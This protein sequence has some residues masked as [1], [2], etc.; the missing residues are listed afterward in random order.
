TRSRRGRRSS[1][2]LITTATPPTRSGLG[3]IQP[4]RVRSGSFPPM[5]KAYTQLAQV[6]RETGL[7]RRTPWFYTAVMTAITLGFGGAITGFILL[8]DSW[9]QL[10]I[11]GG[12]GL[13][14]TQT[15]FLAHEAAHRQIRTA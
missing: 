13:L 14:F 7:L 3:P 9:F 5:A 1:R 10:L 2:C 12:L 11:A 4:T 15:A 6:V 8:G